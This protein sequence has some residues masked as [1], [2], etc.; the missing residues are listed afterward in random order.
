MPAAA[1]PAIY[2]GGAIGSGILSYMSAKG[3]S[4]LSPAEQAAQ[5]TQQGAA[6]SL[7][8]TGQTLL[9]RPEVGRN[10]GR[11]PE[12]ARSGHEARRRGKIVLVPNSVHLGSCRCIRRA[13]CGCVGGLSCPA[14]KAGRCD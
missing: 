5:R 3:A 7:T 12:G 10:V 4:K 8:T 11:R 1:I 14:L 2:A 6:N 9:V 13:R